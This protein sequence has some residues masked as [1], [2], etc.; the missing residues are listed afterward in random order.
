[1]PALWGRREGNGVDIAAL[2]D[3]PASSWTTGVRR[4]GARVAIPEGPFAVNDK[5]R[6]GRVPLGD[7]L[8]PGT[9]SERICDFERDPRK[10]QWSRKS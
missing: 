8:I 4:S 10:S 7:L 5:D 9:G 3:V 1:V 6:P 2:A